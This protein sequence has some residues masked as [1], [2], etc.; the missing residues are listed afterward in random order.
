MG[1]IAAVRHS[2]DKTAS[3][4][5]G[6]AQVAV[7][8]GRYAVRRLHAVAVAQLCLSAHQHLLGVDEDLDAA[9]VEATFHTI[10]FSGLD[11][12]VATEGMTFV[13]CP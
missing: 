3:S 2:Q 9:G 12:G 11:V 6:V 10:A 1:R 4:E 7:R 5:D 13:G 8:Q